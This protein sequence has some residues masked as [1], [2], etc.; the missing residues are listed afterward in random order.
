[1]LVIV[2]VGALLRVILE[3]QK[4][5]SGLLSEFIDNY[6]VSESHGINTVVEQESYFALESI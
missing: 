3:G 6:F 4:T 5:K 2:F 1:M